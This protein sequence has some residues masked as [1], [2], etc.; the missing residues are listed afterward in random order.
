ML[1]P[2][3]L[4]VLSPAPAASSKD[5]GKDREKEEKE[6]LAKQRLVLRIVAELAMLHAWAEGV[7]KGTSEVVKVITSLVGSVSR[8]LR[9]CKLTTLHQMS[10]DAQFN[11]LP[12]LSTFLKSCYR[13]YL[14][15]MPEKAPDQ[16][17]IRPNGVEGAQAHNETL[18][19]GVEE[20]VPPN[21]QERFRK[22]FTTYFDAACKTLVKGQKVSSTPGPPSRMF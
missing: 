22:M 1:L 16:D 15:A 2:P 11:N 7:E 10:N 3:L 4:A 14:G 5:E 19:D 12:L 20:L 13:A 9:V 21:V 18:P 6:R 8:I 17:G